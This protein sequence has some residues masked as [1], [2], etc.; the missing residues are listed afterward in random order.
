MAKGPGLTVQRSNIPL[1][2]HLVITTWSFSLVLNILEV[3]GYQLISCNTATNNHI[4]VAGAPCFV[5]LMHRELRPDD[6]LPVLT[7]QQPLQQQL[8]QPNAPS[9]TQSVPP[10]YE[11]PSSRRSSFSYTRPSISGGQLERQ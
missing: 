3:Q 7:P 9:G 1:S 5:M 2:N 8:L 10:V 11:T 6:Q 4:S